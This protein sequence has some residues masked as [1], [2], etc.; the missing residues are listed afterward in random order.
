[1]VVK[2]ERVPAFLDQFRKIMAAGPYLVD[3]SVEQLKIFKA[4]DIGYP[5][6]GVKRD[7]CWLS[8]DYGFEMLPCRWSSFSRQRKKTAI[9]ETPEGWVTW[10]GPEGLTHPDLSEAQTEDD[11]KVN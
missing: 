1:M 10:S 8:V 6:K 4:Y 9:H 7:W 2:R 3:P 11:G 5:S